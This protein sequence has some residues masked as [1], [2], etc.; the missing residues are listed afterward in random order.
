VEER[1]GELLLLLLLL[2]L[3]MLTSASTSD[4]IAHQPTSSERA[5]NQ[6]TFQRHR[7]RTFLTRATKR[8]DRWH[9]ARLHITHAHTPWSQHRLR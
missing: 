2:L 7:H 4:I 5:A 3:R 1:S 9:D 6:G 8:H